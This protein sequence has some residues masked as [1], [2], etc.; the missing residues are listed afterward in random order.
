MTRATEKVPDG[1]TA[2]Q[3]PLIERTRRELRCAITRCGRSEVT[4]NGRS[5][6]LAYHSGEL[7][8]DNDAGVKMRATF[9]EIA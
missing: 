2:A 1:L 6:F 7:A 4:C 5:D 8:L 9:C 3:A